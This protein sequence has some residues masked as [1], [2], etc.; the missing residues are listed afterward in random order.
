MGRPLNAPRSAQFQIDPCERL[1]VL[2]DPEAR[3][4]IVFVC[5]V[6]YSLKEWGLGKHRSG[7]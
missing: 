7:S 6:L 3:A 1:H 4:N 2:P 5:S